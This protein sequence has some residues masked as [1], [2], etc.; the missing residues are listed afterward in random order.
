MTLTGILAPMPLEAAPLV[1]PK[2]WSRP[3]YSHGFA[4]YQWKQGSKEIALACSGIGMRRAAAAAHC[5][6]E[7]AGAGRILVCGVAGGLVP[8]YRTGTLVLP[9]EVRAYS[10]EPSGGVVS[11][12]PMDAEA[13]GPAYPVDRA[14]R[15]SALA[16]VESTPIGGI[17]VSVRGLVASTS[18]L[19]WFQSSLLATAVDMESAAVGEVCTR[20]GVPFLVVRAFSDHAPELAR[21]DW[22]GLARARKRGW[23][24]L[25]GHL[26]RNPGLAVRFWRLQRDMRGS[27]HR[28]AA[29]VRRLIDAEHCE[30]I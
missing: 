20:A 12:G 10:A 8:G 19:D 14:L 4:L 3:R 15:D 2:V 5:L 25:A 29:L 13:M 27:A 9:Q 24:A 7:E 22:A 21:W 18:I 23:L 6:I 17:L 26:L 30:E 1:P 16:A 28:A 11:Q